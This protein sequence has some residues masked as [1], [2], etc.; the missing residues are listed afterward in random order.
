[1]TRPVYDDGYVLPSVSP[2]PLFNDR[3]S[4]TSSLPTRQEII[5]EGQEL[6]EQEVKI[7]A[8]KLELVLAEEVEWR[9]SCLGVDKP[10]QYCLEV[11]TPGYR[12]IYRDS[13]GAEYEVHT[14]L[15]GRN[16]VIVDRN[17]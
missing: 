13:E 6:L 4:L 9:D 14:D 3:G 17:F 8:E 10:G 2:S 16:K 11:I 7:E 12:L 1:M 5:A 15:S